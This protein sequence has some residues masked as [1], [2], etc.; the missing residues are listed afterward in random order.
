ML[1]QP[2]VIDRRPEAGIIMTMS[3]AGQR[4]LVSP[5]PSPAISYA[6]SSSSSAYHQQAAPGA[7]SSQHSVIGQRPPSRNNVPGN[8]PSHYS[9]PPYGNQVARRGVTGN[10]ADSPTDQEIRVHTESTARTHWEAF[11]RFLSHGIDSAHPRQNK[12]REKLTRLSR[13]QFQ[14]LSTDVYDEVQRRTNSAGRVAA[15]PANTSYHPKRNQAREKLASLHDPRFKDLASDVFFEI[16]RRF[17]G[18]RGGTM[19]EHTPITMQRRPSAMS[20]T[21]KA[22]STSS[23]PAQSSNLFRQTAIVPIKS[24]MIEDGESDYDDMELKSPRYDVD[25]LS[26]NSNDY[27]SRSRTTSSSHQR[28]FSKT[29]GSDRGAANGEQEKLINDLRSRIRDLEMSSRAD[30]N[31]RDLQQKLEEHRSKSIQLEEEL[32]QARQSNESISLRKQNEQLQKELREQQQITEEVRA[33]AESFLNEMRGLSENESKALEQR[34][35]L[36]VTIERLE[37]ELQM[38]KQKYQDCKLQLRQFKTTSQFFS[39][40]PDQQDRTQN[41]FLDPQGLIRDKVVSRFQ[42]A[43]DDLLRRARNEP[44]NILESMKD[45]ILATRSIQKDLDG[46]QAVIVQ[47]HRV[48]KL[49]QRMSTTT[50]NLMTA[51][52]N[53]LIGGDLSPVSLVDAAASHLSIT[54][55]EL[56]KLC[57]L[58][59]TESALDTFDFRDETPNHVSSGSSIESDGRFPFTPVEPSM[60]TKDFPSTSKDL[61]A[62]SAKRNGSSYRPFSPTS[63]SLSIPRSKYL[64]AGDE[65]REFLETHT[66][67]IVGSIQQLLSSIRVDARPG[68]LQSHMSAIVTV[69]VKVTSSMRQASLTSATLRAQTGHIVGA[70]EQCT[71]R[72]RGME[73]SASLTQTG[74]QASKEFKQELAGIAFDTAKQTKELSIVLQRG[75]ASPGQQD[76]QVDLT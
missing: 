20:D 59:P 40:P 19:S 31:V 49:K 67:A 62:S 26:L 16:E 60:N 44:Q 58:K 76:D 9:R 1:V 69:V 11:R 35:N 56:A 63:E 22:S 37:G 29:N 27:N 47:D 4:Q 73:Q 33:E 21:S 64:E 57:K 39:P 30:D 61:D 15:L 3:Y 68:I 54:V 36:G 28:S 51:C 74:E 13:T 65:I 24:M 71:T 45:I 6:E 2:R 70:L 17:P 25:T 8:S 48:V 5:L 7:S 72:M 32:V 34:E 50:N 23:K 14:E 55:I 46:S 53:H 41:A 52:K 66:G 43:I 75:I 38:W 12:A 10:G 18:V 42:M